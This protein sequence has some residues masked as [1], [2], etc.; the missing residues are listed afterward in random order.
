MPRKP[1]DKQRTQFQ[2]VVADLRRGK[3]SGRKLSTYRRKRLVKALQ[4]ISK[5]L[6]ARR[7]ALQNFDATIAGT[8]GRIKEKH[9]PD[10]SDEETWTVFG[11][12]LLV[13]MA[14]LV[15]RPDGRKPKAMWLDLL[16]QTFRALAT[17]RQLST[18]LSFTDTAQTRI[19]TP[20]SRLLVTI[21]DELPAHARSTTP[22]AFLYR[23]RRLRSFVPKRGHDGFVKDVNNLVESFLNDDL[24]R[25]ALVTLEGSEFIFGT[26]PPRTAFEANHVLLRALEP[27]HAI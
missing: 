6:G 24:R 9:L 25:P 16:I 18:S 23:A 10:L 15:L 26:F 11:V 4:F 19:D 2:S 8:I 20:Y 21:W 27:K 1:H 12:L 13:A 17:R 22:D 7:A 3:F 14:P 5:D